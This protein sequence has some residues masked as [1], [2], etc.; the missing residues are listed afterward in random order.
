MREL[1]ELLSGYL[2]RCYPIASERE[3]S[4]FRKVTALTDAELIDYLLDGRQ[5]ADAELA[6]VVSR[7][8]NRTS[9]E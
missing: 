7:I 4:A 6:D 1:D 5:P 8:R 2:D 3:K 9:P